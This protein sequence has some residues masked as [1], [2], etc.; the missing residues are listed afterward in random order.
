[1]WQ[2]IPSA[3][4]LT[5][6]KLLLTWTKCKSFLESRLYRIYNR[7]PLRRTFVR[8]LKKT[9]EVDEN[10]QF[11]LECE[12]SHTVSTRWYH[13]DKE[14]TGMDH[15]EITHVGKIHKLV[16]KRSKTTDTGTYSCR[17]KKETTECKVT[18]KG[19]YERNVGSDTCWITFRRL[20]LCFNDP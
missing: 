15:H 1:V 11:T 8:K 3:R 20:R 13:N 4:R 18:V 2:L 14:L 17:V 6:L 9:V 12:T 10:C 7:V 5:V 19:T 16:V